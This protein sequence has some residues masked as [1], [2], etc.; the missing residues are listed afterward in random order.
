MI[1]IDIEDF[2]FEVKDEISCYEEIG[3]EGAEKWEADFRK[4]LESSKKKKNVI[5]KGDKIMFAVGDES[6][7]FDIAD[8][9]LQALEENKLEEYW[10]SFQ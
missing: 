3:I 8:E 2:I 1:K 9:Y 7:I 4:W 6:E 5:K 10:N